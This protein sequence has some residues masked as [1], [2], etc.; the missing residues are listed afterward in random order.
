MYE[1][2]IVNSHLLV[3]IV[4]VTDTL[5]IQTV[6]THTVTIQISVKY[7]KYCNTSPYI[8]ILLHPTCHNIA[9][10]PD[11]FCNWLSLQFCF[12]TL[13]NSQVMKRKFERQMEFECS[14]VHE[15]YERICERFEIVGT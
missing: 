3:H 15:K 7:R 6:Y 1:I 11:D 2:S 14:I 13:G 12:K 5:H 8:P 10:I 9:K 4:T